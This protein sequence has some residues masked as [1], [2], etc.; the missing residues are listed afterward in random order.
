MEVVDQSEIPGVGGV[1]L[2]VRGHLHPFFKISQN[3]HTL[4]RRDTT[5]GY[6]EI[7]VIVSCSVRGGALVG[8]W[9]SIFALQ[10]YE[11]LLR[12]GGSGL[13]LVDLFFV[14]CFSGM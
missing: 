3:R 10:P 2:V 8:T 6:S 4:H 14:K 5:S 7:V 13:Q 1:D 11:T 9:G 12:S